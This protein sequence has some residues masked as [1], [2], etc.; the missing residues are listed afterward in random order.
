MHDGFSCYTFNTTLCPKNIQTFLIVTLKK[1]YRISIIFGTTIRQ[2]AIKC[3]FSIFHFTQCLF[4]HYMGKTK[5][6]K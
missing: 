5:P 1:N 3:F 4:L 6:T 2:L